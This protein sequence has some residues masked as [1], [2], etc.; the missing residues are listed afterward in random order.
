MLKKKK[1]LKALLERLNEP[2]ILYN[3][4]KMLLLTNSDI[5]AES[6]MLELW[7]LAGRS[8]FLIR[9]FCFSVSG[10]LDVKGWRLRGKGKIG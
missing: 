6:E 3:D 7:L 9:K 10:D 1:P 8:N 4:L 2:E 5:L